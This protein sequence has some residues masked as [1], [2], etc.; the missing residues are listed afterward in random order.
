VTDVNTVLLTARPA[1][2]RDP[3]SDHEP[4]GRGTM[5]IVW[6]ALVLLGAGAWSAL[7]APSTVLRVAGVAA[8]IVSFGALVAVRLRAPLHAGSD[9]RFCR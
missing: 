6:L 4:L 5:A 3:I 7:Q 2:H 9:R 1:D 8:V